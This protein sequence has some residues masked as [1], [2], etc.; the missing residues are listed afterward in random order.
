M[1][2]SKVYQYPVDSYGDVRTLVRGLPYQCP[3][4]WE[5]VL[6]SIDEYSNLYLIKEPDNP[7]DKLAIAA[8]LDDRRVGYVAA[9]DNG[10]IWLYMTDEKMPCQFLER[11]EASFKIV[12]ENPRPLFEEIPFKEI[13]KDN[14]GLTERNNPSFRIPFFT[15]PKD[16]SYDWFD[17]K[18]YIADLEW[19]IPDFRRKLATRMIILL[20]RKNSKGEYCYYLPY[21]NEFIAYVEDA[22]IQDLID[23]HGFVIALPDVPMM[24]HQDSIFMDLHV[25]FLKNTDYKNFDS[26]HH[27]EL[28]FSLTKDYDVNAQKAT[29]VQNVADGDEYNSV[30]DLPDDGKLVSMNFKTIEETMDYVEETVYSDADND[31]GAEI[32]NVVND[33]LSGE[34]PTPYQVLVIPQGETVLYK[35]V[36]GKDIAKSTN[37][38][39]L[40]LAKD[41]RGAI[42]YI[43]YVDYDDYDGEILVY[44]V[45]I[46]VSRSFPRFSQ[47]QESK[48]SITPTKSN[49]NL[50]SSVNDFFP[51]FGV[52]LGKTTWEQAEDMGGEIK[53][54][55]QSKYVWI[56]R[57]KFSDNEKEGIFTSFYWCYHYVDFPLSWKSKGFSWDNSYDEWIEVFKKMGFNI[58]VTQLPS[59]SLNSGNETFSAKFE[60]LSSDGVLLFKMN[61]DNGENT[62][63]TSCSKTLDTVSV[64][65]NG[66]GSQEQRSCCHADVRKEGSYAINKQG[67]LSFRLSISEVVF[68]KFIKDNFGYDVLNAPNASWRYLYT[69]PYGSGFR[70]Y[71]VYIFKKRDFDNPQCETIQAGVLEGNS[72]NFTMDVKMSKMGILILIYR[73][74]KLF[75]PD[76]TF[77]MCKNEYGSEEISIYTKGLDPSLSVMFPV[78]GQPCHITFY[79]S[80]C[81]KTYVEKLKA[82]GTII[83]TE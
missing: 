81:N 83:T 34:S 17:D 19:F 57:V 45:T 49:T 82:N 52:T 31:L 24:T 50:P 67:N 12:F 79:T 46:W 44:R 30:K 55:G 60:A 42:G 16:K 66:T 62:Y 8:Y 41:N 39:I 35:S 73:Y 32:V 28:V 64:I 37:V 29:G 59:R 53:D 68:C 11:F 14:K 9:S 63:S 22:L 72:V 58:T 65:Y 20:G 6:D 5:D 70:M 3:D 43:T 71:D 51:L 78:D 2:V 80:F 36:E 4:D 25:T 10:K 38:E 56:G 15:N 40:E 48:T 77:D 47:N 74:K 21:I 54:D 1:Y 13:Y 69:D 26:A 76:Y 23:R 75:F 18:T 27:S 7:K 33:Y 61:F